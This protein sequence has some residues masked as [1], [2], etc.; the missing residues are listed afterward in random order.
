MTARSL[1]A[2]SLISLAAAACGAR[3]DVPD[4]DD[5]WAGTITTEG[6][7][8]TVVNES[9]SVWGGTATL[10]EELSIGVEAGADAYM[11]GRPAGLFATEDEVYVVDQQV[12]IVRVYDWRGA[13]LRDIGREGQGPGEYM[14][15]GAVI[16]GH[17]GRVYVSEWGTGGRINVYS[18]SGE[19]LDTW[20][21]SRGPVETYGSDV[22][23]RH[24]GSVLLRANWYPPGERLDRGALRTGW[25]EVGPD[26]PIGE[27]IEQPDLEAQR[28]EIALV[29]RGTARPRTLQVPNSPT[30]VS[31]Y[32]PAGAYIFG[33]SGDYTFEIRHADGRAT[34]VER[35]WTPVPVSADE[36]EYLKRT[37]TRLARA[38]AGPDWTYNGPEIPDH[39]PAYYLFTP[40]QDTRVMVSR[41]GPSHYTEGCD[42]TFDLSERP[43]ETCF[44]SERVWDMFDDA[45]RYLGEVA[46]PDAPA[47]YTPF[48]L[49]DRLWAMVEDEAGTPRVKRYRLV[50]P[51]QEGR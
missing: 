7:V 44:E 51:G 45:G 11:L 5:T 12:P 22:L 39:K 8:T 33:D 4:S 42:L 13:H 23:L 1:V 20:T 47:L 40:T 41:Y 25:Q 34:K 28:L 32:S 17:D 49:G 27:P 6:N 16:V 48:W 30:L 35:I 24:D 14:R 21:W 50:L 29:E 36:R 18:A 10:V 38:I 2:V 31:A 15:P 43:T 46:R 19:A 9:G 26:G 3:D 37:T